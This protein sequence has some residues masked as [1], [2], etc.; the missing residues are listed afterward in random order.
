MDCGG[1]LC[2]R[3]S[4]L[5][6]QFDIGSEAAGDPIALTHNRRGIRATVSGRKVAEW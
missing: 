1:Y 4:D 3:T 2:L 5:R 6:P